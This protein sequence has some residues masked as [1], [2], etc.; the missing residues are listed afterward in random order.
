VSD[1]CKL[2]LFPPGFTRSGR[3]DNE[4]TWEVKY[5]NLALS[6][7]NA[8]T[9]EG[10]NERGFAAHLLYFATADFG[11]DNGRPSVAMTMW[12]QYLLDTCA[13]VD[14]ALATLD[15]INIVQLDVRGEKL[16]AH[17]AIE[18]ASGDS[19][20]V[21]FIDGVPVIHRGP[22]VRVMANDPSLDDQ[23]A[24]LARYTPFGGTEEI[25]GN[26]YSPQ[27]FARATY[28]LQYLSE[29][30]D[31][32]EAV[33]GVMGIARSV[34]VPFG[35]PYDDF[36]VYPTLWA[37]VSDLVSQTLYFQSTLAPNVVWAS[38]GDGPLAAAG[39]VLCAD[40]NDPTLTGDI[41]AAFSPADAP[42]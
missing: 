39:A 38:I 37:T 1:E 33:A 7:W 10:I 41:A 5:R 29:P 14:E 42:Y 16:G 24:S 31:F 15:A 6:F 36:S 13:T 26:I 19:A 35:A 4:A 34:S 3:C 9:P 21:E 22:E 25:P 23:L 27:R 11:P 30:K 12:A 32:R 28:F 20:V 8:G 2:W 17:L 40:P 18:D